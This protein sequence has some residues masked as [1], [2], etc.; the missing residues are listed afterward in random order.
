MF[1]DAREI[2]KAIRSTTALRLFNDLPWMLSPT[3]YRRLDQRVLAADFGTSQPVI[4]RALSELVTL[5]L[6]ERQGKGAGTRY[7]LSPLVA[8]R[9]TA[10]QY[11]AQEKAERRNYKAEAGEAAF[12][13]QLQF[14]LK[15]TT[16]ND[17]DDA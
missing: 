7:R 5:R 9:G 8:W 6:I 16:G 4:S 17:D 10:G 2:A 12:V 1:E 15:L 3:D 13:A 14:R 11:H